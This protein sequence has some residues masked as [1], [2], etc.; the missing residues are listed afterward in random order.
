MNILLA[1]LCAWLIYILQ[2]R[3]YKKLWK[4]NLDVTVSFV[5]PFSVEG[6]KCA[7]TEVVE[8]KKWFPLPTLRV[9]FSFPR[10]LKFD[11]DHNISCSDKLYKNDLFSVMPYMR[12]TR[13]HDFLCEKRGYYPVKEASL[14]SSDFMMA[15]TYVENVPEF[16]CLTVYPSAADSKRLL[17]VF[18][19]MMGE[20]QMKALISDPF[21]FSGIRDYTPRDS[22]KQVNWKATAKT[23]ELKVNVYDS[24]RLAEVRLLLHTESDTEWVDNGVREEALRIAGSLTTLFSQKG[25]PVALFS[26]GKDIVSK[27]SVSIGKGSGAGHVSKIKTALARLD[28]NEPCEPFSFLSDKVSK[29]KQ[30]QHVL[31]TTA[32]NDLEDMQAMAKETESLTVFYL[33]RPDGEKLVELE[34]ARV[35]NWEV[36]YR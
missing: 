26:G 25:I 9:K 33:H 28:L 13:T 6:R 7:L 20:R 18:S 2:K 31:I 19:E 10:G 35:V 34:N 5:S 12:I 32:K 27:Q 3:I 24:T 11:G 14:S 4:Q 21:S 36:C 30:T 15:K 22:M 1:V 29:E 8:N 16:A 17:P 23:G